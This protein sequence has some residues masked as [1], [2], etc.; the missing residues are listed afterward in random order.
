[1]N[2]NIP[3]SDESI[4]NTQITSLSNN[5]SPTSLNPKDHKAHQ[6]REE[7]NQQRIQEI[8]SELRETKEYPLNKISKQ[9]LF[10]YLQEN[11]TP[12]PWIQ[13]LTMIVD[14]FRI[15]KTW[16]TVSLTHNLDVVLSFELSE[17]QAKDTNIHDFSLTFPDTKFNQIAKEEWYYSQEDDGIHISA[18]DSFDPEINWV[19]STSYGFATQDFLK[20]FTAFQVDFETRKNIPALN[21]FA[22][23]LPENEE[24]QLITFLNTNWLFNNIFNTNKISVENLESLEFHFIWNS[25]YLWTEKITVLS[26]G[27]ELSKI[28][29]RADYDNKNQI[30]MSV[31][32]TDKRAQ[33]RVFSQV[34]TYKK[35]DFLSMLKNTKKMKT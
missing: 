8:T 35:S 18:M 5:T 22:L 24:N 1:M 11:I 15:E 2:N 9:R 6:E 25:L 28:T 3:K 20:N 4:E 31:S 13:A 14:D 16:N 32:Y 29:L 23:T 33:D 30:M 12:R 19:S 26:K 34:I 27:Q 7:K 21:S 10:S 17:E